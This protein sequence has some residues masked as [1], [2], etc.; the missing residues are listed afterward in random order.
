M[1]RADGGFTLLE[2]VIVV[3]IVGILASVALPLSHWSVKRS[4][5]VELQ[6]ALRQIRDAIDSYH[7]AAVQQLIEVKGGEPGYPP[8]LETLAKGVELVQTE[9]DEEGHAREPR[10]I[11]FLRRIP[12]DPMTGQAEWGLRCYES[13]PD[14][15]FWCRKDVYDVYTLSRGTSIEGTPYSEW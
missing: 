11:K 4:K 12:I 9:G 13:D 3:A 1:R 5:E 7:Q 10:R 15:R 2:L 8:D 14:A 6:E